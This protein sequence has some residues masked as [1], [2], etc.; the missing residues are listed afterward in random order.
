MLP[1]LYDALYPWRRADDVAS[2]GVGIQCRSQTHGIVGIGIAHEGQCLNHEPCRIIGVFHCEL[3]LRRCFREELGHVDGLHSGLVLREGNG[4]HHHFLV[5]Q[6]GQVVL[7]AVA[8]AVAAGLH[9]HDDELRQLGGIDRE[10]HL[11]GALGFDGEWQGGGVEH[12]LGR[13]LQDFYLC[14]AADSLI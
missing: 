9:A 10:A 5:G 8:E 2:D 4:V 7:F 6:D 14:G 11:R 3:S 13:R 1:L 12:F